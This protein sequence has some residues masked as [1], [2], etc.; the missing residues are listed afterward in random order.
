MKKQILN[1]SKGIL[2]LLLCVFSQHVF[3]Q[4]VTV[5]GTVT[6]ARGDALI[7][8]SIVEKGTT[9]GG[10]SDADGRFSITVS[11]G[12]VLQASY[13]GYVAR[14]IVIGNQTQLQITLEEDVKTLNEVVV[15]GYGTTTKK[16]I[17]GSVSSLNSA[18]FKSGNITDPLLLLQGQI[19]GLNI[20]RADGGDPNGSLQIQ[21]RGITTM[22]GGAS[23]LIVIDGVIGGDLSSISASEIQSI[24]VLKDGSAAAIYGTRATNGVIL[25]TTK[26]AETGKSKLE[27]SSYLAFQSVDK[28]PE[29]LTADEF[30]A[31][32][33]K[34][35]MDNSADHGA[36]TDWFNE[37]TRS[38][39]SQN[40]ELSTSGGSRALNYRAGIAWNSDQGLVKKSGKEGLRAR[41]TA[42]QMLINDKL[43]LD[44]NAT[45]SSYK[46]SYADTYILRQAMFHNPTEPVYANEN[47]PA[48]Y[49]NYYYV[50]AMEYYNPVAMLEQFDDSGLR[51]YFNG[52]INA[53]LQIIDGL[54]ANALVSLTESSDRYGHYYGKYHP[55]YIGKNGQAETY[56]NHGNT[57]SI[58][59]YLDYSK[60]F[61]G[62]KIQA[63]GGY[64]YIEQWNESYSD[65]NYKFDTDM[66][67]FYNIGAGSALKDGLASMSSSKS[68]NKLISFFGRVMYN[69]LE[70]Y[71]LT[72]SLRYEGS[73]RFGDNHKW[74]YFPG[75]SLGWRISN[76]EFLKDV[77]WINELKLRTGYGVTGNQEIGNYQSLAI[78]RKSSSNFYY[79]GK[80]LSIYEPGRNPNPDLRWEK[81]S[82]F[83][84]G[85]DAS[86]LNSKLNIN[87]DFYNRRTTD[88]LYT[89]SVPVPPNLYN[90]TFANV[91]TIDNKGLELTISGTP[92][93]TRA[94][95]WNVTVTGS[96][97]ENKM[98]SFSNDTYA[99]DA[100][101][102][103]YFGDD[104]KIYTMRLEEG[105]SL[106]N[107][108]GAKIPRIRR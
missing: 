10:T 3:A 89:Y 29:M 41:I 101:D 67:S 107:F 108:W 20:I 96:H 64:S 50:G 19:A 105:G 30:R 70:K 87:F 46:S 52:S 2:C 7:G 95:R 36:S 99:M 86:L 69:Y 21:L 51:K 39:M 56:N 14:E 4:N 71:L 63:L 103:G 68:S 53:Q 22:S 49:G 15:I 24:D 80:W 28:K 8:V 48:Q 33:T 75:V 35:G 77:K 102:L 60:Q 65:M 16:E 32:L 40:Y 79:D 62:H 57:K 78:L 26:K 83:D 82:E 44:Y 81:K 106:G 37:I 92:Y 55:A 73:S 1:L 5:K 27:F 17:T 66:F 47:T 18:D 25:V 9:N 6:D 38:P 34:Y 76:E 13:I 23:P 43:K 58:E 42:S 85:F 84:V 90:R 94:F 45:Y 12:A 93:E 97:N 61:G 74:G 91:G 11:Q 59:T 31:A 100:L 98:V 54:K 88:L 104:L 72:A